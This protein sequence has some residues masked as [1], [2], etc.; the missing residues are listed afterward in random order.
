LLLWQWLRL[1][2]KDNLPQQLQEREYP[3]DRKLL[4]EIVME[5]QFKN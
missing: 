3:N 1:E 5:G 2:K 4:A